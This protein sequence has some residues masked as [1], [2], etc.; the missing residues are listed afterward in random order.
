M[1][2][3]RQ[4]VDD[5]TDQVIV[6]DFVAAIAPLGRKLDKVLDDLDKISAHLP[7]GTQSTSDMNWDLLS[8]G[9]QETLEDFIMDIGPSFNTYQELP[10]G[11]KAEIW[12]KVND[13]LHWGGR[14]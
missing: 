7:E 3:L 6:T 10:A 5:Y 1:P 2:T 14:R 8:E 11:R 12:K 13:Q 4:R 9:D